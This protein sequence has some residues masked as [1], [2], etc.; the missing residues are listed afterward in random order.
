MASSLRARMA[1]KVQK[2]MILAALAAVAAGGWEVF[3]RES[4][5]AAGQQ[6]EVQYRHRSS[7]ELFSP[8]AAQWTTGVSLRARDRGKDRGR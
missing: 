1:G 4:G 5:R 6:V 3:A 8:A 2:L 7:D